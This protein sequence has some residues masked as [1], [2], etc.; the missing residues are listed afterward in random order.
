MQRPSKSKMLLIIAALVALLTCVGILYALTIWTHTTTWNVVPTASSLDVFVAQYNTVFQNWTQGGAIPSGVQ[1]QINSSSLTDDYWIQNIGNVPINITLT[2][3]WSGS[4]S[5]ASAIWTIEY[6]GLSSV[7]WSGGSG[8][9][10][11]VT[12]TAP[13]GG[14]WTTNGSL[15]AGDYIVVQLDLGSLPSGS[16]GHYTYSFTPTSTA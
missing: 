11:Q 3:S 2:T 6:G 14:T 9:P 13:T 10:S 15:A 12:D 4:T 1:V 7:S 8:T 16:T 5:G